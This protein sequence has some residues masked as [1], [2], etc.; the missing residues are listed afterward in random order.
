MKKFKE[1]RYPDIHT[2]DCNGTIIKTALGI[3]EKGEITTKK[4]ERECRCKTVS[5]SLDFEIYHMSLGECVFQHF[6]DYE[7][8]Q[9][10]M[11]E[12]HNRQIYKFQSV[13]LW[14]NTEWVYEIVYVAGNYKYCIETP[15]DKIPNIWH[16]EECKEALRHSCDGSWLIDMNMTYLKENEFGSHRS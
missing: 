8:V 12:K 3:D 6:K 9:M 5:Y 7:I 14:E 10:R 1:I 4:F 2:P 16:N 15:I 13:P 11:E